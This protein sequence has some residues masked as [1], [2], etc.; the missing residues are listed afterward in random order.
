MPNSLIVGIFCKAAVLIL[1]ET[2]KARNL[3][4]ALKIRTGH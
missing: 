3:E 1:V 4:V 2:P